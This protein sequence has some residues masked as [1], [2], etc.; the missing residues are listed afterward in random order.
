MLQLHCGEKS[1][2][3]VS[4]DNE[5]KIV[6]VLTNVDIVVL[7]RRQMCTSTTVSYSRNIFI[8]QHDKMGP[9]RFFKSKSENSSN[10][11]NASR[12]KKRARRAYQFDE[13]DGYMSDSTT[14][15]DTS[16]ESGISDDSGL[17]GLNDTFTNKSD[18]TDHAVKSYLLLFLFLIPCFF[19]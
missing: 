8:E 17:F 19:S 7:F 5:I 10:S 12:A 4:Y 2:V 18:S 6:V 3:V 11:M 13:L 16:S 14:N 15:S 1:D 9:K